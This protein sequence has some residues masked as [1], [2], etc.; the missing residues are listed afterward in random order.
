LID[1]ALDQL[2][3]Q[4]VSIRLDDNLYTIAVKSTR[5]VMSA[6]IT[7]N[8]TVLMTGARIVA[9]TPLI[10]YRYLEAGNFVLL[11]ENEEY[12]DY[13]KFGSSQSLVYASAEEL[14]ALRNG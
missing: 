3:N 1:I 6:D 14:E 11:T 12:P 7:R 8:G 5:G 10:P 13:T 2:P 9:G 4:S